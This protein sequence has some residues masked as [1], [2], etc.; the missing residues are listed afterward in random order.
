MAIQKTTEAVK[1]R[2]CKGVYHN[3][4]PKFD[5]DKTI[6]GSMFQARK[7]VTERSWWSFAEIESTGA[8]G[9][10]CPNCGTGYADGRGKLACEIVVAMAEKLPRKKK[11]ASQ[12]RKRSAMPRAAVHGVIDTGLAKGLDVEKI[13]DMAGVSVA[14]IERYIAA[15]AD[16]T[17]EGES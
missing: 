16:T 4:T 14:S 12:P 13:A 9:C 3:L 15:Q 5:P 8:G 7:N 1:C 6:N 17:Q 11:P 2:S 10:E